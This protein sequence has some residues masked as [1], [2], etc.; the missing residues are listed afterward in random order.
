M[1]DVVSVCGVCV[2]VCVCVCGVC[3]CVC[4]VCV[5]VYYVR[6][7]SVCLKSLCL[8]LRVVPPLFFPGAKC[9]VTSATKKILTLPM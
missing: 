8:N 5:C 1:H 9:C 6:V 7:V 4:V 3:M 2:C